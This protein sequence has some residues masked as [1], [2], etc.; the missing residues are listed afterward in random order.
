MPLSFATRLRA[1]L[2][3]AVFVLGLSFAEF[4]RKG[5]IAMGIFGAMPFLIWMLAS[6]AVKDAPPFDDT[7]FHRTRPITP[8]QAFRRL[9]GFHLLPLT[10]VLAI[11]VAY[12][13]HC[14][15]AAWEIATGALFVAIPW[16]ALVSLF[17]TIASLT[18][19]TTHS[20]AWGPLA[21][22]LVPALST[23]AM[24]WVAFRDSSLHG[25]PNQIR[26][27]SYLHMAIA[28]AVLYPL[29]W[30]IVS[31][32]RTPWGLG[33]GLAL[34]VGAL[35]PWIS[36][37]IKG[38]DLL[39]HVR[40]QLR[41]DD[42]KAQR[43]RM[44][45][46][47]HAPNPD[48]IP[49]S[50][51]MILQGLAPDE[52]IAGLHLWKRFEKPTPSGQLMDSDKVLSGMNGTAFAANSAGRMIPAVAS[53]FHSIGLEHRDGAEL[54]VLGWEPDSRDKRRLINQLL[55]LPVL[56]SFDFNLARN[57]VSPETSRLTWEL[58]GT[59]YQWVKILEVAAGKTGRS[60]LPEGGVIE[61]IPPKESSKYPQL[62]LQIIRGVRTS[63]PW[64]TPNP[65]IIARMADGR[66][67]L[68]PLSSG[69]YFNP[70]NGFLTSRAI[71]ACPEERLPPQ[72][73]DDLK[74]ARLEV[75]WPVYRSSFGFML[76]PPE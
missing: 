50:Q 65:A 40:P 52:F 49:V 30:W 6:S 76:P 34:L 68:V 67:A 19:S 71:F 31:A 56:P 72:Q 23:V 60:N 12:G 32:R 47:D 75:Y 8:G 5:F 18:T 22:L 9:A 14:N 28:A 1:V 15:L 25:S 69:G 74:N 33:C 21:G 54:L 73:L 3:A 42:L 48:Q 20:K 36:P 2:V 41:S 43:I 57:P 46:V 4:D 51:L 55:A 64:D 62:L 35:L 13:C 27:P 39:R 66:A 24:C 59:R 7:G 29:L 61:V 63:L 16:I 11:L 38:G 70:H 26:F 58:S 17:A 37:Q 10:G 44:D 45:S 53:L